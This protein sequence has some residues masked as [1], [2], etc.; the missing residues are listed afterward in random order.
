[1][2]TTLFLCQAAL[3]GLLLGWLLRIWRST[4]AL[5]AAVLLLPQLGLVYDNLVTGLGSV[6]G[7]GQTLEA[8]SWPRFWIH[9]LMGSWLI[10]V[11]G[12]VLRMAGVAW[13]RSRW[14]MGGF[15]LLTI[16]LM[17]H[18]L[19]HF[20]TESLQPVCEK[21]LVRYSTVVSAANACFA[22]QVPVPSGGPPLAA[23][24]ACLIVIAGGLVLWLR[25]AF[26]WMFAGALLML[27]SASPPLMKLK[28]DN[29]GEICIAGGV[30]WAL[31]RFASRRTPRD[32]TPAAVQHPAG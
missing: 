4:G 18:E 22:G 10:I 32:T 6:V 17:A 14:V 31:A 11:T 25:R 8:L 12:A 28:L 27:V 20:W 29:L 2:Y 7:L 15:C 26:P 23:L 16:A 5:A 13:A 9:W 30:I 24:T 21:G 19:P 3:Q 1:M